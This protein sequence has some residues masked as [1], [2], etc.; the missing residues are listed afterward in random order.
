MTDIDV[1]RA[2]EERLVNVWPAVATLVMD[3]WVVRFANGYSG[4]ANS[5]SA[6]IQGARLDAQLL[7]HIERLYR[8]A[9]LPP[10]VRV[11]PVCDTSVEPML[12]AGGYRVKDQSRIMTLDLARYGGHRPDARVRIERR[13]GD[14]WLRGVASHQTTDKQNVGHLSAIVGSI[15]VP[16]AF[17][18]LDINGEPAGFG[19]CAVD[20]GY[21]EIG[22]VIVAPQLRGTGVGRATVDALLAWAARE[23]A[24]TA[25]LQVD[26]T[27]AVAISLYRSQGFR[28]LAGYKTMR[29][30]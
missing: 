14:D 27:N 16:A 1:V 6:I 2:T 19:M 22:S 26:A 7:D 13:P 21:A 8:Q 30:V 5:A 11:T 25:F 10:Q 29:L 24:A 17:A 18:I 28:D 9:G 15:R 12:S 23:G 20:R 4:R 3:G